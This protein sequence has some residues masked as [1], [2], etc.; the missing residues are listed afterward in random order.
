MGKRHLILLL[1]M[2]VGSSNLL[3]SQRVTLKGKI[4]LEDR[5]TAIGAVVELAN[6]GLRAVVDIDGQYVISN[7]PPTSYLLKV[8]HI[9][10]KEYSQNIVLNQGESSIELDIELSNKTSV[11]DE[12][13]VRAKS[14]T[15]E[16]QQQAIQIES[17]D[18]KAVSNRV[19][20]LSEAIDQLSGVR[21]RTSGSF[22]DRIDIS[23][24]GLNGTA[25]RVYIDGLPLEFAYPALNI[26]NIPLTNIKRL[27]VYKGVLPVNIGT[28]AMGG[29]VNIITDYQP[30]NSVR[31]SYSISSFNTH[32]VGINANLAFNEDLIFNING[33][34]NRSDNNYRMDAYVWEDR[35]VQEVERFHDQYRLGFLDASLI[36][37]NRKWT[38]FFRIN[39]N[40]SDIY[41]ELQNGGL[42]ERLAFGEA[43]YEGRNQNLLLDYR[44]SLGKGIDFENQL[45]LSDT[46]IIFTDSTSNT[47]SWSGEI[48][49][50]GTAGEFGPESLSD[51]DQ[52]NFINRTTFQFDLTSKDKL[53]ISN[54]IANQSISGR[55]EARPIERDILTLPQDLLKDVVGLEYSR[56]L[57][58]D[59]LEFSAAAKAYYFRLTGVDFR[60]F[61]PIA[62]DDVSYGWYSSIKYNFKPDL[63]LRA[64]YERAW[65]IPTSTQFF[66]DGGSIFSNID[67]QPE[68]SDNYNAGVSYRSRPGR[69]PFRFGFEA[70]GFLRGQNDII[71]LT[72]DVI[73]RYR[74][75]EEVRTIGIEGEVFLVFWQ[76][77]RFT[78]NITQLEKT[79]ES[80]DEDNINGQFLVGTRF[81]NTPSLFGNARLQY[82]FSRLLADQDRLSLYGQYKYV[83][84]F[85]FINVGQV[86]NEENWVPAQHRVDAGLSYTTN[87]EDITISFNIN[88]LL[89]EDLFDNFKIPR[90]GRNYSLKV[91]YQIKNFKI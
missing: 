43:L 68:S 26:G 55:D 37:K 15:T 18:I 77:L 50:R 34:Y 73:Q 4:L 5:S 90:P 3:H 35:E 21:V 54:L 19:R 78:G 16:Q 46:K 22:G 62:K 30:F 59:K 87:K 2:I 38:D 86:R 47:Y 72:P 71:F 44:K 24:N 6:T 48:V 65:R 17:V 82:T 23:L 49:N 51:R 31:A 85:N 27:D 67:L 61:S 11:L 9:G 56:S 66:G 81:P 58:Q 64:S 32:Q 53:L 60:S 1:T 20:E 12:V 10:S 74:N 79:Y 39:L 63:F 28:D 36:I 83:D 57:F 45:A 91:A 14:Q 52:L 25:V 69:S 84:E 7:I 41:K 29:G 88:N 70:N 42:V 80:I 8:S 76:N 40:Y 89:N 13:T 75:A 33:S